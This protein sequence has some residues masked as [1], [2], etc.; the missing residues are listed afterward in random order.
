MDRNNSIAEKILCVYFNLEV[1][2]KKSDSLH[3]LKLCV[4]LLAVQ[5]GFIRDGEKLHIEFY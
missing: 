4:L 5:V 3:F 2:K 1:Q